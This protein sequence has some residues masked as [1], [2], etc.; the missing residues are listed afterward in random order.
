MP[1]GVRM[2]VRKIISFFQLIEPICQTVWM[3]WLAIFVDEQ[4]TG[5]FPL[6]GWH[7]K[8]RYHT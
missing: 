2:D 4:K 3:K 8:V 1:K 7:D 6:F 5:V